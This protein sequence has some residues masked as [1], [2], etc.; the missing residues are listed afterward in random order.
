M[1]C[2]WIRPLVLRPQ[3]KKVPANTQKVR[4]R[5]ALRKTRNGSIIVI[6]AVAGSGGGSLPGAAP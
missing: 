2:V 6:C 1:K 3:I 5:D 4:L